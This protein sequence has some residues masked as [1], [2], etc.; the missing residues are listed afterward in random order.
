MIKKN[1]LFVC[2]FLLSACTS[3]YAQNDF[4]VINHTNALQAY[5]D[6]YPAEKVHI[7]LD[8][9]W[10]GLGDTIWFK[11]YI[12]T[13]PDHRLSA[14]SSALYAELINDKDSVIRRLTIGIN[15]GVSQGEFVIPF[16]Y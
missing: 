11:A 3:V 14:I 7:H 16:N 1:E 6:K 2:L 12:V 15:S 8:R 4:Q 5:S 9:T 10:Y 13:G